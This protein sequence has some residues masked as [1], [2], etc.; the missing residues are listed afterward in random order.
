MK[1]RT[2][3]YAGLVYSE[4]DQSYAS[5]QLPDGA[6]VYVNHGQNRWFKYP[7]VVQVAPEDVPK[8]LQM[9]VMLME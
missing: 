5:S 2:A 6:Y 3:F 9:L 4:Q 1:K 7:G 8:D